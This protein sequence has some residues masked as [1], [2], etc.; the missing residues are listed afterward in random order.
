[1]VNTIPTTL[2]IVVGIVL[3]IA[4]MP[5]IITMDNT[6]VNTT[7]VN[8][9]PTTMANTTMVNTTMAN[10]T[11]ANMEV[12]NTTTATTTMDLAVDSQMEVD[13]SATTDSLSGTSMA[14][15]MEPVKG[16]TTRVEHGATQRGG[17]TPDVEICKPQSGSQTT[18]GLIRLVDIMDKIIFLVA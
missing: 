4:V 5:P 10:T 16:R 8:T 14:T 6:M 2:A 15:L 11:T 3:T 7:M 17:A 18:R 9:I 12:D 13:V 1:M